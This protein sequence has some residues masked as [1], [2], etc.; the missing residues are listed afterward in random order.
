MRKPR[1]VCRNVQRWYAHSLSNR[2]EGRKWREHKPEGTRRF[3]R[4]E[5]LEK[6]AMKEEDHNHPNSLQNGNYETVSEERVKMKSSE[7]VLHVQESIPSPHR[8]DSDCNWAQSD[9][10]T[11]CFI[12]RS[13]V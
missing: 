8:I 2:K 9:Y 11:R 10:S 5:V 4:L 13:P 1:K 6:D 3:P 7:K 12:L